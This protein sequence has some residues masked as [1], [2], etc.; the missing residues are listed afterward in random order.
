V[1]QDVADGNTKTFHPCAEAVEDE[2]C[3]WKAEENGGENQASE[4]QG[5]K[6]G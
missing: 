6:M 3:L 1:R 5:K 2:S 4:M